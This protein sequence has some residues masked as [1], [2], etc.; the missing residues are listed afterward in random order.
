MS[1]KPHLATGLEIEI[2]T[3]APAP[4]VLTAARFIAP[5]PSHYSLSTAISL[6]PAKHDGLYQHCSNR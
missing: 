6:T 1:K 4:L 5:A 2:P 3:L